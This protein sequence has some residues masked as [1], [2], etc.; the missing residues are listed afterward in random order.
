MDTTDLRRYVNRAVKTAE[1]IMYDA[2]DAGDTDTAL[3]AVTRLTQAAQ[4]YLKV[5]EADELEARIAAL[6]KWVEEQSTP[7]KQKP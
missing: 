6:E 2:Y 7:S 5:I 1:R 3:K 4:A